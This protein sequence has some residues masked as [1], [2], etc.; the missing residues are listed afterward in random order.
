ME[1]E[2][3]AWE[4]EVRIL[5]RFEDQTCKVRGLEFI[6]KFGLEEFLHKCEVINLIDGQPATYLEYFNHMFDCKSSIIKQYR[7]HIRKVKDFNDLVLLDLA[8]PGE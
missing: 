8:L 3:K 1:A 7:N 2:I 5:N 4:V 6:N